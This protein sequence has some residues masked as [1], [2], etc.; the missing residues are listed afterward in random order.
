[1]PGAVLNAEGTVVYKLFALKRLLS[2]GR[3]SALCPSMC[4]PASLDVNSPTREMGIVV[5]ASELPQGQSE[6][7][8][9]Y[10]VRL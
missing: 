3:N 5:T 7:M 9:T 8:N 1:M 2:Q 6:I 4:N 10:L